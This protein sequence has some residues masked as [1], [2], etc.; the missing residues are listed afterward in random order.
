M[1]ERLSPIINPR[2][3]RY[4]GPAQ[5]NCADQLSAQSQTTNQPGSAGTAWPQ[6]WEARVCSPVRIAKQPAEIEAATTVSALSP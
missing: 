2:W 5:A 4:A 6:S 3:L 1:I